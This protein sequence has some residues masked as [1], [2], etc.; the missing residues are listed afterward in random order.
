[1]K[2]IQPQI[3]TKLFMLKF[4]LRFLFGKKNVIVLIVYDI[5]NMFNSFKTSL[6]HVDSLIILLLK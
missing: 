1:M 2:I 5:H 3:A 4:R 6:N